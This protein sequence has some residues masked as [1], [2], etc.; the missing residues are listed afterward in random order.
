MNYMNK[1]RRFVLF[2]TLIYKFLFEV[3]YI[4]FVSPVFGYL[5]YYLDRNYLFCLASYIIILIFSVIIPMTSDVGSNLVWIYFIVSFI[6]ESSLWWLMNRDSQYFL[7]VI[8]CFLIL[9]VAVTNLPRV[10]IPRIENN[11]SAYGLA[12]IILVLVVA[13]FVVRYGLPRWSIAAL[14]DV[15]DI[16]A[17]NKGVFSTFWQYMLPSLNFG[18]NPF[19]FGVSLEKG[20]K[21]IAL[22]SALIGIYFFLELGTKTTLLSIFLMLLLYSSYQRRI[23]PEAFI[24]LL[25]VLTVLGDVLAGCFGNVILLSLISFRFLSVPANLAF[26]HYDFFSTNTKLYFSETLIGRVFDLKSPYSV[27]STYLIGTGFSNANTGFLSDAYDQGGFFVMVIYVILLAFLL[28][29][30]NSE[31]EGHELAVFTCFS[32]FMVTLND[33]SLL[34]AITT[35]GGLI[36]LVFLYGLYSYRDV[37]EISSAKVRL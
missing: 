7:M 8:V 29:L 13:M 15:Y 32:Y 18:V 36:L 35:F 11:F 21:G 1:K 20:N 19:I 28:S 14:E 25:T 3:S 9:L 27:H 10:R 17:S 2:S 26:S 6:P 12:T 22:F 34:T 30:V 24:L 4:R 16:R 37:G 23:F 33:S 5:G 31:S